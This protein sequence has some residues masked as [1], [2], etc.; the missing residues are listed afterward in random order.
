ME[1][2]A[3]YAKNEAAKANGTLYRVLVSIE[4]DLKQIRTELGDTPLGDPQL[5]PGSVAGRLDD[6]ARDLDIAR[7]EASRWVF[8]DQVTHAR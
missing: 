5:Q 3:R 8:M 6:V 1:P 2:A 4:A 7:T